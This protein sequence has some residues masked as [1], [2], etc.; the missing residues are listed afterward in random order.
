MQ[1]VYANLTIQLYRELDINSLRVWGAIYA[2]V[3]LALWSVVFVR[4]L[5]LLRNGAIFESPCLEEIDMARGNQKRLNE[6]NEDIEKNKLG[7][8]VLVYG[9]GNGNSNGNGLAQS[10]GVST[11]GAMATSHSM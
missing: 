3:T 6:V 4:T 7:V 2:L 9:N 5:M 10:S 8:N 1:G 11:G